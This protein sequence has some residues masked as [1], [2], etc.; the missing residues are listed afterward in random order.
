M[1]YGRKSQYRR[2]GYYRELAGDPYNQESDT[3]EEP[4][5]RKG[6]QDQESDEI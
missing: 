1:R 6:S 5:T 2:K 3:F 4:S